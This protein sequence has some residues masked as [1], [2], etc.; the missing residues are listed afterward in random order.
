MKITKLKIYGFGKFHDTTID[1]ADD[2][3]V[4]YGENEAG[5]S[6]LVAFITSLLF[7]FA[8]G[9]HRYAMYQPKRG[10]QYGGEM[11]FSHK[12]T[13]YW[14]KRVNGTHGGD[15][16]LRNVDANIDLTP[17]NLET[18]LQPMNKELFYQ[19]FCFGET[20]LQAV[21]N[22]NRFDLI[23]RIQRIG[24]VG[25]ENWIGLTKQLNN[26][27]GNLY[28]PRGRVQPLVR[29]LKEYDALNEKVNVA[30]GQYHQFETLQNEIQSTTTELINT[31]R[32]TA[33]LSDQQKQY[34]KLSA[35]YDQYQQLDEATETAFQTPISLT[36]WQEMTRLT[37]AVKQLQSDIQD[38]KQ[39]VQQ[40]KAAH[41]A[42]SAQ[43][44]YTAHQQQ[45]DQLA[46]QLPHTQQLQQ[47]S[48]QIQQKLAD[49]QAHL[50]AMT[51]QFGAE[52]NQ[53]ATL[54]AA[55]QQQ[56]QRLLDHQ[57]QLSIEHDAR[58]KQRAE[59][60]QTFDQLG[61]E[62]TQTA[63]GIGVKWL[64]AGVA[65]VLI[66][67]FVFSGVLRTLGG[68]VGVLI[69]AYGIFQPMF[70]NNRQTDV[71]AKLALL[72]TQLDQD[73]EQLSALSQQL[74]DVD[75]SLTKFGQDHHL[76]A[77]E[78]EQWLQMQQDFVGYD[79]LQN[80]ISQGHAQQ[81]QIDRQIRSY[82]VQWQFAGDVIGLGG[83]S[84]YQL[85]LI[86]QF[87][88]ERRDEGQQLHWANETVETGIKRQNQLQ[89]QLDRQQKA[90]QLV[91]EKYQLQSTA[92]FEERY[93]LEQSSAKRTERLTVMNEQLTQSDREILAK[94]QSQSQLASKLEAVKTTL[95]KTN[96]KR[97]ALLEKS[98]RQD[99]QQQQLASSDHYQ[100]L[101]QQRADLES[102]I[103]T[104]TDE[105][106]TKQ[107]LIKWI[108][109]TLMKA[110]Q[111][112]QPQIIAAAEDFFQK[113]TDQSYDSIHFTDET[114][115]V[116]RQ[117][118]LTFDVGELSSGTAEQLY[119]AL[120][121]AFTTIMADEINMPIIIDD[122]FVNFDR[123]RTRSAMTMLET[124]SQTTQILY[125]TANHDNLSFFEPGQIYRLAAGKSV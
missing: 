107:L 78:P 27:A 98:S 52:F 26:D 63:S 105:W 113:L 34:E 8:T 17:E 114:V 68:V 77:Y 66:A 44:F 43:Q 15:L 100:N 65:V 38:Q 73:R 76:T 40:Q 84:E 92:D 35:L 59:H 33:E 85:Q 91:L 104:V 58:A 121:F 110:S 94:T 4:I 28:K 64:V 6:T 69:A 32:Q 112:R 19:I 39:A 29:L 5:K 124:M 3:Q 10:A 119:V 75:A 88:S 120:R 24:A 123:S 116:T 50:V 14:L 74:V 89:A 117:D 97:N 16:T 115:R 25:S 103:T 55:E 67:L 42:S 71:G 47:Q 111:G 86:S 109:S 49:E 11:N 80:Q 31:Q 90:V 41:T 22:L 1:F 57:Q 51:D 101:L 53:D 108:D 62:N 56:V 95:E 7:G 13:R 72:S 21:F 83:S 82:L 23:Q 61:G 118:G 102:E 37:T 70:S 54:S 99:Y 106:L 79:T 60:Q 2:F 96:Q 46:E 122:A 9:K 20:E 36:G 18:I 45:I 48:N 81:E 87:L 93:R 30:K 12:G 125:L